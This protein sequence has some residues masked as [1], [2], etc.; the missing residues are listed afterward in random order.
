MTRAE[1]CKPVAMMFLVVTTVLAIGDI[2]SMHYQKKEQE[3][4]G[5]SYQ[6]SKSQFGM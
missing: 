2:L 3:L 4:R 1:F 6:P 5:Q